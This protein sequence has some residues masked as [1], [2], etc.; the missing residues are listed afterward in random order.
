MCAFTAFDGAIC[1]CLFGSFYAPGLERLP[2]YEWKPTP[3][4]SPV[5]PP[6]TPTMTNGRKYVILPFIHD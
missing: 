3:S 5:L 4:P 2:A 1:A 6:R